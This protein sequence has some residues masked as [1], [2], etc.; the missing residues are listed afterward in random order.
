MSH[1]RQRLT[2]YLGHILQAIERI[3]GYAEDI[4]ELGFLGVIN[5][6][7]QIQ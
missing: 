2:D 3:H 4:D 7:R 5:L 6:E 1:D